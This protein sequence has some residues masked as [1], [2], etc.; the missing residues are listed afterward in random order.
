[1]LCLENKICMNA[2]AFL[3]L[4]LFAGSMGSVWVAATYRKSFVGFG[5]CVSD[6]ERVTMTFETI[7]D[8]LVV[9]GANLNRN[10]LK[11]N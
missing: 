9:S 10:P 2:Y 7:R 8:R 1:M 5:G 3:C 4:S 11:R 6:H